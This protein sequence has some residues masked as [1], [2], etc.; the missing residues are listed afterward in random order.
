MGS[1]LETQHW[2]LSNQGAG[3]AQD[4]GSSWQSE[5]KDLS[6]MNELDERQQQPSMSLCRGDK[7]GWKGAEA[8][9]KTQPSQEWYRAWHMLLQDWCQHS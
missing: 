3:C 7:G 9:P 6:G 4:Q 2:F 1:S 8:C 5:E